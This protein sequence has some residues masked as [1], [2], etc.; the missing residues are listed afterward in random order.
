MKLKVVYIRP[1]SG[2][3]LTPFHFSG[4]HNRLKFRAHIFCC[5]ALK[6][7]WSCLCETPVLV[8][9]RA[10]CRLCW[11]FGA[12]TRTLISVWRQITLPCLPSAFCWPCRS[13]SLQ[14]GSSERDSALVWL[15]VGFGL[16]NTP[17]HPK[18]LTWHLRFP[19]G[20]H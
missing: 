14:V 2:Y 12:G 17:L 15:T 19:G 6:H 4:W 10:R 20:R 1:H 16:E 18:T 7:A 9:P 3:Q 13:W 5:M 8:Y 11:T